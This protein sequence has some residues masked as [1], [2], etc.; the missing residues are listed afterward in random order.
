MYC[1]MPKKSENPLLFW[2]PKN[3]NC[4]FHVEMKLSETNTV[5]KREYGETEG[6]KKKGECINKWAS[7]APLRANIPEVPAEAGGGGRRVQT[8]S[9][10]LQCSIWQHTQSHKQRPQNNGWSD[11]MS[12]YITT[13]REVESKQI[14]TGFIY[15]GDKSLLLTFCGQGANKIWIIHVKWNILG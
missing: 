5:I 10:Q 12:A 2:P 11:R 7:K 9:F 4:T 8:V 6:T 15:L 14:H 3:G 13:D 1:F